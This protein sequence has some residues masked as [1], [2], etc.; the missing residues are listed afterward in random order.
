MFYI[1]EFDGVELCRVELL[2]PNL[3]QEHKKHNFIV[4]WTRGSLVW[5]REDSTQVF[6]EDTIQQYQPAAATT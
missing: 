1:A 6:G 5:E 3:W 2:C 4:N